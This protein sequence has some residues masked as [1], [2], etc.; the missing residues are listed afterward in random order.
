[1]RQNVL[2]LLKLNCYTETA[3]TFCLIDLYYMTPAQRYPDSSSAAS[4]Y[5]V[6]S[7]YNISVLQNGYVYE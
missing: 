7:L 5:I 1:M 2:G 3:E 4:V 6:M